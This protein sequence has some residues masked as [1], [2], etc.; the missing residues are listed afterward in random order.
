MNVG[1]AGY[2]VPQ[3]EEYV[4]RD[5]WGIPY[6]QFIGDNPCNKQGYESQA[7]KRYMRY[8]SYQKDNEGDCFVRTIEDE[9]GVLVKETV[10]KE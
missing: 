6:P 7:C 5:G 3:Q 1:C 8:L 10:C 2:Y 4:E 9:D